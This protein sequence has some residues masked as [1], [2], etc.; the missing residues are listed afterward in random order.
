MHRGDLCAFLSKFLW[1]CKCPKNK[2]KKIIKFEIKWLDQGHRAD[3]QQTKVRTQGPYA[4][5]CMHHELC[6]PESRNKKSRNTA[7]ASMVC[8]FLEIQV[9][10]KS[11]ESP[12]GST[13][14]LSSRGVGF[15]LRFTSGSHFPP[16]PSPKHTHTSQHLYTFANA[17]LLCLEDLLLHL[18]RLLTSKGEAALSSPL[19]GGF[20]CAEW[21]SHVWPLSTLQNPPIEFVSVTIITSPPI[22]P[23][24]PQEQNWI[25]I[26]SV[27]SERTLWWDTVY[28]LNKPERTQSTVSFFPEY[29]LLV[30]DIITWST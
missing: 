14:H 20:R 25:S 27:F 21:F 28:M 1:T 13:A 2:F 17:V 29:S 15:V 23:A 24:A 7:W 3:L 4:A 9:R 26:T 16:V 5:S 18:Q 10:N 22:R 12:L 8:Y 30:E 6:H 19:L 11:G